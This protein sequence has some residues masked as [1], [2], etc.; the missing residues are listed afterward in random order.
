[1]MNFEKTKNDL[2]ESCQEFDRIREAIVGNVHVK[3]LLSCI[4]TL[5]NIL[6]AKDSKLNRA[7]GFDL[8]FLTLFASKKDGHKNSVYR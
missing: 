8:K 2:V 7:D 4:L 6:N 3:K 5:G 1:M